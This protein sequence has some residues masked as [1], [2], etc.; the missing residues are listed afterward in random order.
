MVPAIGQR[1]LR[2]AACMAF[3]ILAVRGVIV[4]ASIAWQVSGRVRLGEKT[5]PTAYLNAL[6]PAKSLLPTTSIV[7]YSGD[8]PLDFA[9]PGQSEGEY[10]L[11][12]FAVAPLLLDPHGNR[13]F[14]LAS[15][16]SAG[17]LQRRLETGDLVL[18]RHLGP[19]Q[20]ILRRIRQP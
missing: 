17:S 2:L 15:F 3:A 18:V 6:A 14:V 7:G 10:Y 16:S 20:A 4:P 5:D 11:A 9:H 8:E 19:G 12:Q 13:E 1:L